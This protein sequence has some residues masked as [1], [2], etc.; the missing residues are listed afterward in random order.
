MGEE[1]NTYAVHVIG[2]LFSVHADSFYEQGDWVIFSRLNPDNGSTNVV[3]W[4]R[5]V[6]VISVVQEKTS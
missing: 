6:Q 4:F 2:S 5:S 1:M 3:A